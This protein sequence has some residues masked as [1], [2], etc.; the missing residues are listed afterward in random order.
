MAQTPGLELALFDFIPNFIFLTG[1][2]YLFCIARLVCTKSCQWLVLIGSVMIFLAGF[3]KATWKLVY[4]LGWEN[5]LWMRDIQYPLMA[6]GYLLVFMVM[7]IL[8]FQHR[9][10]FESLPAWLMAD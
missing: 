9:S 1:S 4:S 7:M 8:A 2:Y 6:P 5:I 10:K 3:L